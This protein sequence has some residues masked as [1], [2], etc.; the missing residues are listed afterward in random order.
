MMLYSTVSIF[1]TVINAETIRSLLAIKRLDAKCGMYCQLHLVKKLKI[2]C[3][4][5]SFFQELGNAVHFK[6]QQ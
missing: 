2:G 5:G 4:M 6:Q 1:E 3:F